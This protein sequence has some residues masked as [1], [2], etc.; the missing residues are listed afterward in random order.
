[1][2]ILTWA[3]VGFGQGKG[4]GGSRIIVPDFSGIHLV[5]MAAFTLF[6]K[7]KNRSSGRTITIRS[8]SDPGLAI[9]AAFRVRC[10]I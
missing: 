9:V 2:E 1:M 7:K 5:P 4:Q 8:P 6:Q 3:K 10:E